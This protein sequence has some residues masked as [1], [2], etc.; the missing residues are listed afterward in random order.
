[1]DD[2]LNKL[3][4]K[5]RKER[6]NAQFILNKCNFNIIERYE[7]SS[8]EEENE[9]EN[10]N[11]KGKSDLKNNDEE[12]NS[13]Y[14]QKKDNILNDNN[15]NE[16]TVS[17]N[18]SSTNNQAYTTYNNYKYLNNNVS[19]PLALHRSILNLQKNNKNE[20]LQKVQICENKEVTINKNNNNNNYQKNRI[21]YNNIINLKKNVKY[22]DNN[23][24]EHIFMNA[25]KI[26]INEKYQDD[27]QSKYNLTFQL[28]KNEVAKLEWTNP[29]KDDEIRIIKNIQ[30]IKL[31][32]I[33]FDF[34]GKLRI[35][36]NE[37]LYN[38]K[39]NKIIFNHFNGLY[40]H[41]EE[42][43]NSGYTLPEI[44][45]LC[46]SSYNNQVCISLKIL[47]HVFINMH[48]KL[49][50]IY[51]A[52]Q[53]IF[54][55]NFMKNKY[56]YGFT[57]KRFI[58]YINND[59]KIF[60]KLLIIFNY[61]YNKN[62]EI[63]CLH[64]LASYLFPNN[65]FQINDNV[66]FNEN[67]DTNNKQEKYNY[68]FFQDYQLFS[69]LNFFSD[70][71]F[72]VDGYNIYFYSNKKYKI[73]N[74][75]FSNVNNKNGF[76]HNILNKSGQKEDQNIEEDIPDDLEDQMGDIYFLD[77]NNDIYETKI[78]EVDKNDVLNGNNDI[79]NGNND[80]SNGNNVISNGNN[81]I[82]N[83]NNDIS[84][85][86]NDISNGN[87]DISNGNN[88]ISND[89]NETV[90]NFSN[91]LKRYREKDS[92]MLLKEG[93][94]G[95][96]DLYINKIKRWNT[97]KKKQ[98]NDKN[99][100]INASYI[101]KNSPVDNDPIIHNDP[102]SKPNNKNLMSFFEYMDTINYDPLKIR[103]LNFEM[104]KYCYMN[105]YNYNKIINNINNILTNN[106]AILEIENS[107]VCFLIGL[108]IK[109]K[110]EINILKNSD[111]I[112]NIEKILESKMVGT[113]LYQERLNKQNNNK[114]NLLYSH[115]DIFINPIHINFIY[116]LIT[117]I[118][119]IIIYNYDK[120]ILNKI[121]ILPFLDKDIN[122][123]INVSTHKNIKTNTHTNKYINTPSNEEAY[124]FISTEVIKIFRLLLYCN[125]YVES[126]DY[127]HD[128]INYVNNLVVY[129]KK[130]NEECHVYKM[131]LS[132]IYLYI[133]LYNIMHADKEL[134][135]LLYQNKIMTTLKNYVNNNICSSPIFDDNIKSI[136]K[137][138]QYEKD[139][140]QYEKHDRL[141]DLSKNGSTACYT[142]N[143]LCDLEL[144]HQCYTYIYSI[145]IVTKK[146]KDNKID[147]IKKNNHF[148]NNI[149][150]NM[151][152]KEDRFINNELIK[153]IL[154]SIKVVVIFIKNNLKHL[155]NF[156]IEKEEGNKTKNNI[157]KTIIKEIWEECPFPFNYVIYNKRETNL[158]LFF[159]VYIQILNVILN[160]YYILIHMEHINEEAIMLISIKSIFED[161]E[162][163]IL[164]YFMMNV[165]KE[166][167][168]LQSHNIFLPLAYLFYNI[169]KIKCFY[170]T[171]NNNNNNNNDNII[172]VE[173]RNMN[174]H[175]LLFYSLSYSS[176]LYLN[177]ECLKEIFNNPFF[178]CD[179]IKNDTPIK[180]ITLDN[181][182]NIEAQ[183]C[184]KKEVIVNIKED[185]IDIENNKTQI[186]IYKEDIA[187]TYC[188]LQKNKKEHIYILT[189]LK[190][191]ISS[192]NNKCFLFFQSK[193]NLILL[194]VINIFKAC[195]KEANQIKKE[196]KLN[197][198]KNL[199]L[200]LNQ[201]FI[202]FLSNHMDIDIFLKIFVSIFMVDNSKSIGDYVSEER[203]IYV[204]LE[205]I[206]Y[207][208]I[209]KR[210]S[211]ASDTPQKNNIKCGKRDNTHN[212]NN[213]N[214]N[215]N[216]DNNNNNNN[217]N[218]NYYYYNECDNMNGFTINLSPT[219]F[220]EKI[221]NIITTF[222]N[223]NNSDIRKDENVPYNMQHL[224]K[225]RNEN[226]SIT[227]YNNQKEILIN[228][229]ILVIIYEQIIESYKRGCFFNPL[230]LSFLFF[231]SSSFFPNVCRELFFNDD[232]LIKMLVKN[233][234]IHFYD[235]THYIIF[236]TSTY[237]GQEQ[238][239]YLINI[240]HLFPPL[241][242]FIK[243]T[244]EE[245][246]NLNT[247]L[248]S[249]FKSVKKENLYTSL[250]H[251]IF[252]MKQAFSQK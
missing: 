146:M 203:N 93:E 163:E 132:Q 83:G 244:T 208:Y 155:L 147:D 91:F 229:N 86:N 62:V 184:H 122:E 48:I 222:T 209:Y 239:N 27:A 178:I 237:Y 18:Q 175:L 144:L 54:N 81:D 202:D 176:S 90:H 29:V 199:E 42:P 232:D 170:N 164:I 70:L 71:A 168:I 252:Y 193:K 128:I 87:N 79:S 248:E 1:M 19:F 106:F 218:N 136:T 15:N 219:L 108:L 17:K 201:Y 56:S 121:D 25:K 32:E 228:Q 24:D 157:I 192:R 169:Y 98:I 38:E 76:G 104:I 16:N 63:N 205:R 191:Y 64:A 7:D 242:S 39:E 179:N 33:R 177:F 246:I 72:F 233:V 151:K 173:K 214:D 61:Y 249:Y 4:D 188:N 158:Y 69:Y 220:L 57:Y 95:I 224:N 123:N 74:F 161:I 251:F 150:N 245:E 223:N 165:F 185:L 126:V 227:C 182:D 180:R 41:N 143:I 125:I 36:I 127:F 241:Y 115:E 231:F 31:H 46:Q 103:N 159:L 207:I 80:I 9:F 118:K 100:D 167:N 181:V 140:P 75:K 145:F 102:T 110:Q 238:N 129:K 60:E 101:N 190:K 116:N 5:L 189:F 109:K 187:P 141:N 148:N 49:L 186:N 243:N 171:S 196:E 23:S 22:N 247:N 134:S 197:I 124:F 65:I 59:L 211:I 78:N 47:K 82:S 195:C 117:L 114:N 213:N 230:F 10:N 88:D 107:C 50:Y 96:N 206:A 198:E 30:E 14:N 225:F 204:L 166:E 235:N 68:I 40:H 53:N 119:Y 217:G 142:F 138:D 52:F 67:M 210:I 236:T 162:D 35:Q 73:K 28:N 6:T 131:F 11:S 137:W 105:K 43:L 21:N 154:K 85:G 111:L 26:Y 152:D 183:S 94:N 216:N 153:D 133:S 221:K 149:D 226:R 130:K 215:N 156:Y 120:E 37:K 92:S 172:K 99:V 45:Y 234:F 160:I 2:S 13:L 113:D 77:E 55:S 97:K 240:T 250:L 139:I 66:L 89:N 212:N 84:N 44:L 20:K 8:S 174:F 112:K 3:Q 200:L 34:Q 51:P 135:G 194:F 12:N 58:N